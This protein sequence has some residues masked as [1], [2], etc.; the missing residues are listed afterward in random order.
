MSSADWTESKRTAGWFRNV[1]FGDRQIPAGLNPGPDL[2]VTLLEDWTWLLR[3]PMQPILVT[4]LG[5]LFLRNQQGAIHWLDVGRGQLEPVA[6]STE[7]FWTLLGDPDR[8]DQWLMPALVLLL[9]DEH[10]KTLAPGQCY[11]FV[12]CP[13][14]GGQWEP[15]NFEPIDLEVYHHL[16]GQLH[17][18]VAGLPP[19]AR[20]AGVIDAGSPI[21]PPRKARRPRAIRAPARGLLFL[22]RDC[23][24]A[25]PGPLPIVSVAC[26]GCHSNNVAMTLTL[27]QR[28][29]ALAL[30]ALVGA[31]VGLGAGL[32][33]GAWQ[34]TFLGLA[35]GLGLGA[36]ITRES[37]PSP[38]RSRRRPSKGRRRE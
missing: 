16:M 35:F 29:F 22:C 12:T 7:E 30:A 13:A 28:L 1:P 31:G 21:A 14:L 20:I 37:P 8:Q 36:A 26:P 17:Q 19:G 11:G 5:D 4:C 2:L 15:D 33:L 3:Q 27:G 34:L 23:D 10:G 18:Q 38:S 6:R 32:Y 24:L 25:F 9:R